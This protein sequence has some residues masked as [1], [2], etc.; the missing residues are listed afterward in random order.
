MARKHVCTPPRQDVEPTESNSDGQLTGYFSMTLWMLLLSLGY[1]EPPLF[2]ITP[3]LLRGNTYLWH[4]RV[5]MYESS[6]INRIC[7]IRQVIKAVAPRWMFE[8]RIHDNAHE[9]LV[10]VRHEEDDQIEHSQ[11]RHFLS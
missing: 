10:A 8:G 7:R 4:V 5:V 11:Y 6:M 2:V 3:R 9:A 1:G